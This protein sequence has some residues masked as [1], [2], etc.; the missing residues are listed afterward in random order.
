MDSCVLPASKWESQG[1][2]AAP[3][4]SSCCSQSLLSS[5]PVLPMSQRPCV[6]MASAV[7]LP[8]TQACHIFAQPE[9]R[10]DFCSFLLCFPPDTKIRSR[11]CFDFFC[12]T[13]PCVSA[14]GLRRT[15]VFVSHAGSRF[16]TRKPPNN[17]T[18]PPVVVCTKHWC[19]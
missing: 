19:R 3:S 1:S 18:W 10:L 4:E 12:R 15:Q 11:V 13:P 14:L 17:P 7:Q 6:A 16:G 8:M 9:R 5:Y 2:D